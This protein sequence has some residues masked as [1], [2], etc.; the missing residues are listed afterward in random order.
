MSAQ[1][2]ILLIVTLMLSAL[3]A[4]TIINVAL[5][6]REYAYNNAIEK[7]K[8]TA[9][10]VRDGLTA[11]MV[12]GTM[13][14]RQFFLNS[15]ASVKDVQNLWIVRSQ[16]V[17][18][19]YGEG[20]QS[21]HARDDID[22]SVLQEGKTVRKIMESAEQA[23]LRVTIPYT[24]TGYSTPN[25]LSCHNVQDGDVLGAISME[26]DIEDIRDA[27]TVTIMKIFGINLLFL[28]IA[29][30]VTLHYFRPYMKL[31]ADMREGIK[32][33]HTGDFSFRIST[34][35]KNEGG[36]VAQQI[37]TLFSKMEE[38]FGEL[39]QSLSTFMARSNITYSDPLYEAKSIIRELSEVYKFKK[40][41]ELDDSKEKIY[42]R[43]T[44]VLKEKFNISHFALYEVDKKLK[45]R[46][47]VHI[48]NDLESFCHAK[49]EKNALECRA[50]RTNTDVV[51]TDF[52]HLCENCT[53]ATVEYICIPFS[54]DDDFSLVL[55]VSSKNP[56]TIKEINSR[57]NSIKNYIEAAKPVIESRLLMDK[58]R[59]SSLR[60]GMTGLYNRRFLEEFIDKTMYQ[61]QR[62][63]IRYSVLM[64]DIDWFK[65]VNDTYG[66]DAGDIVIKGLSEVI[67]QSIRKS[68]LAIRFG[69]EE[70]LVLLHSATEEGA[71][72]VASKI[73]KKFNEKKFRLGSDVVQKTLSIG[74]AHF[75]SQTDSIW[76]AIKFADTA[77]YDAK[78]SGRNRVVE[79]TTEMLEGDEY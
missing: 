49:T 64:L 23:V 27:G 63:A 61:S 55:S 60:D 42:E 17:T 12:N 19:Q 8:M 26:F 41:I 7:S 62:S 69:G 16:N 34:S 52:P 74:V 58:L 32:K 44:Y 45:E 20:L 31:F 67:G 2:R 5:N 21:E 66:H 30:W 54:I 51:S 50:F 22:R 36:E 72:S 37:N 6:F 43:L 18:D 38:T 24:A 13:D 76:K 9:E 75:P 1:R 56:E 77:L 53:D 35:V 46:K 73:H 33:A 59:D 14:K 47:L 39:K 70:F 65:M 10:I 78:N 28:L 68:D 11:H 40:T 15:I 29:I 57:V 25:C 48:S 79:F 3:A 71:L 4:A